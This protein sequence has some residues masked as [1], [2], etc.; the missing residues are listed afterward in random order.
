MAS[1]QKENGHI[2]IANEIAEALM[3]I[4]LS[5]YE[6]RVLWA[7]F[8]KTYG[9]NK[10]EDWITNSQIAKM[11]NIAE[12]HVSRTI[13][14]LIQKNIVTKNGKKLG[15]QKDYDQWGKLPKL[16]SNRQKVTKIGKCETPIG[17]GEKV[18]ENG[19]CKKLPIQDKKL[20]K[21]VNKVTKNGIKKLPKL[22][23]TKDNKDT[24]TKDTI[25]KTEIFPFLK[26]KNFSKTF[27]DYLDMRKANGK[28]TTDRAIELRLKDLHTYDIKIAIAMLEQSIMNSWQGVF[29]LKNNT[30]GA[31][32]GQI[33]RHPGEYP[34]GTVL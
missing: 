8:R 26:D 32:Y 22:V 21:M 1:P 33:K 18:T 29:P 23:D 24:T 28:K 10:T 20:P 13:K 9:W 17:L 14:I 12:S 7:I 19:K 31:T 16:V 6:N 5:G 27:Q 4:H 3:R 34:T 2:S 11:I 15:F 30:K 25:Q